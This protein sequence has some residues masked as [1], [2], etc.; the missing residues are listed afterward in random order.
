MK[1]AVIT[2]RCFIGHYSITIA[3]LTLTAVPK[4]NAYKNLVRVNYHK[5]YDIQERM[6]KINLRVPAK[7]KVFLYPFK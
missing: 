1:D 3:T 5:F 2:A 6:I 7:S 4:D